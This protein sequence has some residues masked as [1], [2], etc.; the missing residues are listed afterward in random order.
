MKHVYY[1]YTLCLLSTLH[2]Q[3]E[4]GCMDTSYHAGQLN[5]PKQYYTVTGADGGPCSCPCSKYCAQYR[6]SSL[7][8][9][10]CP[11]CGHYRVPH[12]FVIVKKTKQAQAFKPTAPASLF[13]LPM[14]RSQ[15]TTPKCLNSRTPKKG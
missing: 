14:T 12:S 3:A 7:A 1:G 10:K 6:C 15:T 13:K 11:V 4:V 2:A 9:G 8:R 5:D